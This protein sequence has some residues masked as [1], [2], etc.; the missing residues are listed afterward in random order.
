M[1]TAQLF[2][3]IMHTN[4]SSVVRCGSKTDTKARVKKN[5]T[6]SNMLIDI[7]VGL[8]VKQFFIYFYF[9]EGGI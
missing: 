2:F 5:S 8:I 9:G 6:C 4:L 1:S 7:L 3:L